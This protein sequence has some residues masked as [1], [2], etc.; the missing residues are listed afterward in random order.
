MNK[1][2][3]ILCILIVSLSLFV[4]GCIKDACTKAMPTISQGHGI[5]SD[6]AVAVDQAQ[7][8]L[9][10]LSVPADVK[11]RIT[12]AIAKARLALRAG[13]VVLDGA[14]AAC[15]S[16]DLSGAFQAFV[17]SWEALTVLLQQAKASG[18]GA[19]AAPGPLPFSDPLIVKLVRP[20]A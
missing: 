20:R 3:S 19:V 5:V 12:A 13:A 11:E 9:Q 6:A 18:G 15:S 14:S 16:P 1:L 2:A 7:S 4:S 17:D 10:Q 8:Y